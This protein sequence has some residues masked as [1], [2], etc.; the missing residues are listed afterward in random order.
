MRAAWGL[1]ALISA[2]CQ[3]DDRDLKERL[4][5]MLERA[6]QLE[7][8]LDKPGAG[9]SRTPG[10]D[11]SQ[12]YAVPVDGAPA[13]GP[14]TAKVTLVEVGEFACPFCY[15][16][17][18]I[19]DRLKAEY[20]DDLRIVW[21]DLIVHPEQATVA[22]LAGCAANVQ[23]RFWEMAQAIW[24]RGWVDGNLGDLGR[25]KMLALAAELGLDRA[26][27]E[28]DLDGQP[29]RERLEAGRAE[30]T[31]LGVRGT[32]SFFVN[33]RY[34]GGDNI[35]GDL[36]RLIE[37]ER[38]KATEAIRRGVRADEYYPGIVAGGKKSR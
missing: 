9:G 12:V 14:R 7:A 26:R 38:A 36:R 19:L 13:W 11:V 10:P 25:D 15:G 2:G 34:A 30:L 22:A 6:G 1:L 21:R 3:K 4:D 20:G 28:R 31:R 5:R 32:P 35:E 18:P 16:A 37:E 17:R 33:G 29:C 8:K 23:H 27:F 24:T